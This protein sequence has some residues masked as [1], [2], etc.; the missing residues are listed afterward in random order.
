M[1]VV[2]LWSRLPEKLILPLAQADHKNPNKI[3]L[4]ISSEERIN[5]SVLPPNLSLRCIK[6]NSL[7]KQQME[8]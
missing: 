3:W 4:Q 7:L 8:H 1:R 5:I 6:P 2:R